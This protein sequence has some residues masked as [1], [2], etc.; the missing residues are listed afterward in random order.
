MTPQRFFRYVWRTNGVLIFLAALGAICLV[1]FVMYQMFSD[2]GHFPHD[3]GPVEVAGTKVAGGHESL[4]DLKR[5]RGT[6]FYM[7]PLYAHELPTLGL[8]SGY[9]L[10]TLNYLFFDLRAS[11]A[12]WLVP[13]RQQV[14]SWHQALAWPCDEE[15]APVVGHLFQVVNVD[16]NGDARLTGDDHSSLAVSDPGGR[17][18]TVLVNDVQDLHGHEVLSPTRVLVFFSAAEQLRVAEVDIQDRVIVTNKQ[19]ATEGR[20]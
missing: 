6:D 9:S 12:H 19:L 13:G 16:T 8:S 4:G 11:G 5:V 18:F 17:R 2:R 1:L 3:Q 10:D 20:Q 14:F 15:S 7:A